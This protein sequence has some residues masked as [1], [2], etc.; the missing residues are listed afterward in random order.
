MVGC[1]GVFGWGEVW[2]GE[3]VEGVFVDLRGALA[4]VLPRLTRENGCEVGKR[5]GD[6]KIENR[7]EGRAHLCYPGA[8]VAP[9]KKLEALQLCL[10]HHERKVGPRVHVARHLLHLFDL[11]FYAVV[12]PV[13]ELAGPS[14]LPVSFCTFVTL[15]VGLECGEGDGE[16]RR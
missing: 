13:E 16:R 8:Q 14:Y 10:E 5:D 6:I 15:M 1:V 9:H 12:Y 3:V 4:D 7:E 11:A 2:G